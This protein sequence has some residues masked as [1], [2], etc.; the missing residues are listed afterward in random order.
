MKKNLLSLILSL[1]I[2]NTYSQVVSKNTTNIINSIRTIDEIRY[3]DI[4]NNGL[5]SPQY[6]NYIKLLN[7]ASKEELLYF[8][9]DTSEI[10]KGYIYL[11]LLD[12]QDKEIESF[13]IRSVQNKEKVVS[14]PKGIYTE[15]LL[16][17]FLRSKVY[18][19]IIDSNYVATTD[20]FY[21]KMASNF[22]SI[23]IMN[24]KWNESD[25]YIDYLIES[26]SEDKEALSRRKSWLANSYFE[27]KIA[28][29]DD[30]YLFGRLCGYP[31]EMPYL[32]GVVEQL[33][34]DTLINRLDYF[35]K[36]ISCDILVVKVYG[37]E[38]LIRLQ[39]EGKEL[40]II[41]TKIIT[42]FKSSF[43]SIQMCMNYYRERKTVKFALMDYELKFFSI[44]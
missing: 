26:T 42:E 20:T 12:R 21:N 1:L 9:N 33:M 2:C 35:D 19:K 27:H 43:K 8:T 18:D 17:D 38:A 36:W 7:N 44:E 14:Y 15:I 6:F 31:S 39:N 32:R 22:D 4:N 30:A 29:R 41:Q 34:K 10:V 11:A 28:K 37:V 23:L 40:S 5:R 25:V 16:S 24:Y 13:Y 3:N